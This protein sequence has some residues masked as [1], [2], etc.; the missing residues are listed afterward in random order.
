MLHSVDYYLAKG[1]KVNEQAK[2]IFN[3]RSLI[4]VYDGWCDDDYDPTFCGDSA[5]VPGMIVIG[6]RIFGEHGQGSKAW[7]D[8]YSVNSHFVPA[9]DEYDSEDYTDS[10]APQQIKLMN[11]SPINVFASH[12][13]IAATFRRNKR[14]MN[15]DHK[16]GG[17]GKDD[18]VSVRL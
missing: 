1:D 12:G 15:E 9:E 3:Y 18:V 8:L 10:K 2:T 17:E 11:G 6:K 5:G 7:I 13:L 16:Q 4:E 14:D